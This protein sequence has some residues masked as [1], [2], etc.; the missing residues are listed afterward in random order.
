MLTQRKTATGLEIVD[1]AGKVV[2]E[3]VDAQHQVMTSS[4]FAETL[5]RREAQRRLVQSADHKVLARYW[6][7]QCDW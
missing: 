3:I 4:K 2:L 1:A 6:G 7:A 5:K